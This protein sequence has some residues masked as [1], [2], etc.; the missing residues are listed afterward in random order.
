MLPIWP[1]QDSPGAA[2]HHG[3]ETSSDG[4]IRRRYAIFFLGFFFGFFLSLD[5]DAVVPREDDLVAADDGSVLAV[6]Y[7][8]GLG[9]PIALR[10]VFPAPETADGRPTRD[11][12]K[13]SSRLPGRRAS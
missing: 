12:D 7:V 4:K 5:S 6:P 9:V 8:G 13:P 3:Q 1:V 2:P 10:T 11:V